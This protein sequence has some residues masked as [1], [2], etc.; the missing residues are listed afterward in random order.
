MNMNPVEKIILIDLD[1]TICD[2][3]KKTIPFLKTHL[4]HIENKKDTWKYI[5]KSL[6]KEHEEVCRSP[7]F[8]KD[9]EVIPGSIDAINQ[10]KNMNYIVK[11]CSTPQINST[12]HSDKCHWISNIFIA[13]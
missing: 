7:G 2:Y 10:M 5:N 11:F 1:E 8:F 3:S 12:S 6:K 13:M 9:L 4:S